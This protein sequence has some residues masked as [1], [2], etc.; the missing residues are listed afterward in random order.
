MN[1]FLS[2]GLSLINSFL[3][4]LITLFGGVFGLSFGGAIGVLAGL[5]GGFMVA[6]LVCGIIA[7]F[8]DI[9]DE[10]VL[11]NNLSLELMDELKK[12]QK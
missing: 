5:V 10:L 7:V 11:A 8:L 1:K 6:T 9:R 2:E 3:A 4:I 12:E